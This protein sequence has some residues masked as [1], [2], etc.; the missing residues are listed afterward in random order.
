MEKPART[1][2]ELAEIIKRR[3]SPRAFAPRKVEREV[4]YRL[5]EAAR[6]APSAYNEQPWRFIV[7][8]RETPEFPPMLACLAEAN[9]IWAQHAGALVAGLSLRNFT[10]NGKA[11]R[12]YHHDLG[13][14]VENFLLRAVEEGV[15]AHPMAGFS[16]SLVQETFSVPPEYD[17]L[18]MIALGY[19]GDSETLPEELRKREREERLRKAPEDLFF[20]KNWGNAFERE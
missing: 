13:L 3:W 8:L 17:P 11:N 14:A 1:T 16:P 12:W 9:Q 2:V 19:P 10:H 5:L 7:A 15:F 20:E 4:L 6:W 18:V